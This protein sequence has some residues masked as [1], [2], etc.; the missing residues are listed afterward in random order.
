MDKIVA[1]YL[2]HDGMRTMRVVGDREIS[3]ER[4]QLYVAAE[5]RSFIAFKPAVD[6]LLDIHSLEMSWPIYEPFDVSIYGPKKFRRFMF[7]H[8]S[9]AARVSDCIG[10]ART[11][12]FARTRFA[13]QFAFVQNAPVE[14][15]GELVH[16]CFLMSAEWMPA[17]C[18]AIGGRDDE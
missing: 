6:E 10:L 16:E 15:A 8:F 9:Y 18:V 1:N 11:E 3:Q 13:P 2:G 17:R 7:I 12:F 14:K 4:Y 5:A